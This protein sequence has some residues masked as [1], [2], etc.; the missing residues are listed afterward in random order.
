MKTIFGYWFESVSYNYLSRMYSLSFNRMGEILIELPMWLYIFASGVI[1]SGFAVISQYAPLFSKFD[2]A[3][4]M[5]RDTD[6]WKAF[7]SFLLTPQHAGLF[8]HSAFVAVTFS[9]IFIHTIRLLSKPH[10]SSWYIA[11]CYSVTA[12]FCKVVFLGVSLMLMLAGGS[13]FVNSAGEVFAVYYLITQEI[14][15]KNLVRSLLV[16]VWVFFMRLPFLFI[17]ALLGIFCIALPLLAIVFGLF[18]YFHTPVV[19]VVLP[20]FLFL[21]PLLNALLYTVYE[22]TYDGGDRLSITFF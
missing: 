1:I 4:G 19:Y 14:S 9:I 3:I 8:I 22:T 18:Y 13:G 5:F 20:P 17:T 2:E 21:A 7:G 11:Y 12:L 16:G 15:L 6:N 10:Y